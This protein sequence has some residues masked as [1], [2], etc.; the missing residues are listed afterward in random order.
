MESN[1][2][3]SSRKDILQKDAVTGQPIEGQGEQE[4][5]PS[6]PR[7]EEND[8][9]KPC[10]RFKCCMT[11]SQCDK[12]CNLQEALLSPCSLC[13]HECTEHQKTILLR[14]EVKQYKQHSKRN[15][16]KDFLYKSDVAERIVELEDKIEQIQKK[17]KR[18]KKEIDDHPLPKF[19][20]KKIT[21]D[22]VTKLNLKKK[23]IENRIEELEN[24]F[25]G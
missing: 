4:M 12:N 11:P 21:G 15:F 23:M 25:N 7:S 14:P 8:C 3:P 13:E 18:A 16:N 19:L 1:S 22:K 20:A 9:I 6:Y 17:T 10:P 24:S 5:S 2:I